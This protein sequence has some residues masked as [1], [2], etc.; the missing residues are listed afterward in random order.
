MLC[1]QK[2]ILKNLCSIDFPTLAQRKIY[3]D[4]VDSRQCKVK[5]FCFFFFFH[6]EGDEWK[7][8]KNG[9]VIH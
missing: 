9:K 8:K 7:I 2:E 1:S 5:F 3:L 6:E 4:L